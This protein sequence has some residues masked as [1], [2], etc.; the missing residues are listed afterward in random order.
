VSG[1]VAAAP[2]GSIFETCS[3]EGRWGA[4][5]ERGTLNLIGPDVVKRGLATVS[6]G[7]VVSLAHGLVPG[8][9]EGVELR[10]WQ[11]PGRRDAM[12][13]LSISPHGFD[14]THL[15]A[16]G[17]SFYHGMAYNGRAMGD[18]V[19]PSG[20]ACCGISAMAPGIVTRA[21][22]LDVLRAR[23]GVPLPPGD[24]VT[25]DDMSGAEAGSGTDVLPGDAV[26]VRTGTDGGPAADGRRAGLLAS[27][28]RWLHERQV[29]IYG[30]DC[31][32]CLPGEDAD[33][34]MVLHQ[35]G[36]VAMGLAILD[37]PAMEVARA[38]CDRHGREVFLLVVAPLLV[39]GATGCAVNPLAVF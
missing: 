1:T 13:T 21:V 7:E 18:L 22:L 37:N 8:R 3:N 34:P 2:R 17:H 30:G 11:G 6:D 28:V 9:S 38:A 5:D 16:I 32:E 10:A 31:I 36:H 20:L 12:D 39:D 4:E 35:V 24:G 26:L 15:D 14:V 23:G 19:G 25:G 33:L 27:A 29:A